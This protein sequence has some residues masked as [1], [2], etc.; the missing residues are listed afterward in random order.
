MTAVL[1]ETPF[2]TEFRYDAEDHWIGRSILELH[3]LELVLRD[4]QHGEA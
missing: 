1:L 3:E 2:G 4:L